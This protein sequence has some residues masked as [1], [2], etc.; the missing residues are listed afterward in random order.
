MSA[1]GKSAPNP[2]LVPLLARGNR[3]RIE[4]QVLSLTVGDAR[5][6]VVRQSGLPVHELALSRKRFSPGAYFE[7][8]RLVKQ[9]KPDVLHAW[10][11]TAQ[12][13]A[14]A[15]VWRGKPDLPIVWSVSRTTPL[16]KNDD[17]LTRTKFARNLKSAPSCERIIYPSAVAAANYRRAGL[18]D[19]GV[20]IAPGV[21]AERFKP[22][23]AARERVRKQL[24]L[25]KEAILIG[26]YAPF[27]P[28][29]DHTTFLKA[30]GDL[31]RINSNLY[32]VLAGRGMVKGN[33]PL[34]ALLGGTLGTR[35]RIV[36][37]WTDVSALFNAC[38][39]VCSSATNDA[40]RLTLAMSMLCGVMCVA[41][42]VGAQGE[43]LGSFGV[44]VELGSADAMARG[45][46]RILDMP[47]DRRT[48]M[49]QAARKHILQNFNMTRSIEK[50]HELYV[51]LIT[52]E[53]TAT[54]TNV[55]ADARE[56]AQTVAAA[57]IIASRSAS[58]SLRLTQTGAQPTTEKT[59]N[60]NKADESA[61]GFGAVQPVAESIK[62]QPTTA[63]SFVAQVDAEAKS[64]S[65]D[66]D[67][68]ATSKVPAFK[69]TSRVEVEEPSNAEEPWSEAD[70]QL[71]DEI[72]VEADAETAKANADKAAGAAKNAA[73]KA[74][75]NAALAAALAGNPDAAKTLDPKMLAAALN[76]SGL[77]AGGHGSAP[78][79]VAGK[80]PPS[81]AAMAKP[82]SPPALT[83]VKT[84]TSATK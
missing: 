54:A 63:T 48:F 33:A 59:A 16:T 27:S 19:E 72:L 29:F 2:L 56:A 60:E 5:Y 14:N 75:A 26:M 79:V 74:A 39:V 1:D 80:A 62:T 42:G 55:E 15:L 41:T 84:G 32:C 83:V 61:T 68:L 64:D 44:S 76:L 40:A 11:S 7:A 4:S 9:F 3:Q 67:A 38:D 24:E 28:E 69:P 8:K 25:P 43:V 77:G 35:T 10:G 66:F 30:I 23:D 37:E 45:I 57:E 17:W 21:D 81:P 65:I 51:E 73:T 22:D 50:Y 36:G 20:V 6:A 46:R 82:T 58:A 18:P 47:T 52:G 71:L 78:R 34:S 49:A 70:G 13:V 12:I 53:A 31:I